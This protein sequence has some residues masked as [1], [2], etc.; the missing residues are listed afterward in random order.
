VRYF[1]FIFS[2]NSKIFTL[3]TIFVLLI[4]I[5]LEYLFVGSIPVFFSN[6]FRNENFINNF[7]HFNNLNREIIFKYSILIILLFLCIKN[8]FYFLNQL[9][10]LKFSFTIQN[11][12]S[13]LILYKYLSENYSIFISSDNSELFRNVRDNPEI[14]RL[15]VINFFTLITEI[16]VFFGLCIIIIYNSSLI[17]LLCIFF[18]VIF[19]LIYLFFSRNF[20]RNW[21]LQRQDFEKSKIKYLQESFKGF[22]EL[23]IFNK[24]DLFIKNYIQH[25][26]EANKVNYRFGLLYAF[27]RIYLEIIGAVGLVALIIF[28]LNKID[29]NS[30]ISIIPL[31][32][33]Y[34][35]A[36]MRL[37]PSANRILNSIESHRFYFPVL[38]NIYKELKLKVSTKNP[39][40]LNPIFFGDKG[41][42]IEL[43]NVDFFYSPK[44]YI[45]ENVNIKIKN[46]SKIAIMGENGA[47]KTT[48]INLISGLLEPKKGSILANGQNIHKNIKSWQ[49]NIAY[50]SQSTFLINDTIENNISFDAI[51]NSVHYDKLNKVIKFLKLNNLI[52][53][54]PKGL[55]TLVGDEGNKLSGGQKQKIGIARALYFDRKILICDEITSSLDLKSEKTILECLKNINKTIIIISHKEKNLSFCSNIFKLQN[56]QLLPV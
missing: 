31:I 7:F 10:F 1:N 8:I 42:N 51:K 47:G 35:V 4:S 38:K 33:L 52:K 16:L 34:F 50:I 26:I 23:K 48:F 5:L 2:F 53:K 6:I 25:N 24:Q 37:L 17:S 36:F 27:P 13:K 29:K 19:S 39:V 30:F 12:L 20:S 18:L 28:N 40:N 11:K 43:K 14:I 21:S 46:G 22:K 54:F 55:D 49:S 32:A 9:F 56:K 15:L 44:N 45:L 41:K 3:I